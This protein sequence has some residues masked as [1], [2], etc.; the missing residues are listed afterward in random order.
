[1]ICCIRSYNSYTIILESNVFIYLDLCYHDKKSI[2]GNGVSYMEISNLNPEL[3]RF[4]SLKAIRV[5]YSIVFSVDDLRL[6]DICEKTG[7]SKS[8]THRILA[9]LVASNLLIRENDFYQPGPLLYKMLYALHHRESITQFASES[10]DIINGLTGETVNLVGLSGFEG[11]Y[12]DK[13]QAVNHIS[14]RSEV[15]WRIPLHCTASGKCFLAWK[16]ND[17]VESYYKSIELKR[18]TDHTICRLDDLKKEVALVHDRGFAIDDHEHNPDVVCISVPVFDETGLIQGAIGISA[19]E[20]RFSVKDALG[21]K[22]L[23]K[24]ESKK[25]TNRMERVNEALRRI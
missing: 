10:M 5:L 1:M 20:Y 6:I 13:R 16:S 15:G 24:M 23:L 21:F 9:D 3:D 17:W 4:S 25:I 22:E 11:V 18:Y 7:L 14:M 19:P 12:I 8:T 2:K